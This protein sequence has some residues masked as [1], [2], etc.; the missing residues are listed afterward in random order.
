MA[1][2][3]RRNLEL[4]AIN[5]NGVIL[6]IS[7]FGYYSH[8]SRRF[9][10]SEASSPAIPYQGSVSESETPICSVQMLK[11]LYVVLLMLILIYRDR[12]V[13]TIPSMRTPLLETFVSDLVPLVF[14]FMHNVET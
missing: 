4:A 12:M 3:H 11:S 7:I 2:K 10:F 5:L 6:K 14:K 9:R 1:E 8:F 13:I